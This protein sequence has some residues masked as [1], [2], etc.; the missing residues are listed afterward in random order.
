MGGQ[1]T[2]KTTSVVNSLTST[3]RNVLHLFYNKFPANQNA[4]VYGKQYSSKKLVRTLDSIIYYLYHSKKVGRPNYDNLRKSSINDPSNLLSYIDTFDTIVLDE[5]QSFNGYNR[6]IIIN[7]IKHH[8]NVILLGDFNQEWKKNYRNKTPFSLK[9]IEKNVDFIYKLNINYRNAINV[10]NYGK[11]IL[12]DKTI[13]GSLEKGQALLIRVESETQLEEYLKQ[14]EKDS[15]AIIV[16]RHS[17]NK[18]Q[19]I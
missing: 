8:P 17:K 7:I 4:H 1:G 6:E 11:R 9:D 16:S 12:D 14:Y 10:Y 18:N 13:S 19:I 15:S 3:D 5:I 2:G